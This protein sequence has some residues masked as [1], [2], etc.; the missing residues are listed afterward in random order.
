MFQAN[1]PPL[2]LQSQ[3]DLLALRLCSPLRARH[4]A[5]SR[6]R[7]IF[8]RQMTLTYRLNEPLLFLQPQ[9]F[10]WI[11]LSVGGYHLPFLFVK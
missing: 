1:R 7:T 8:P 6:F 9:L 3:I 10:C 11:Q 5:Q 4:V 2:H